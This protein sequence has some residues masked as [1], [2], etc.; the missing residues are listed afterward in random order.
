MPSFSVPAVSPDND[1]REII[2]ERSDVASEGRQSLLSSLAGFAATG[3]AAVFVLSLIELI[4]LQVHLSPEFFSLQE[5]LAFTAYSSVSLLSGA[6]I[7]LLV[8]V[9]AHAAELINRVALA[10][11]ARRK[12]PSRFDR[13]IA[14]LASAA[15]IAVVFYFQPQVNAYISG[16]II[17]AQKLPYIYGRLLRFDSILT[18][19]IL[20]ALFFCGRVVLL[21]VRASN[22]MPG[23]MRSAWLL[24]LSILIV[25]AY[26]IDSQYE[27]QLYE[28]TLHRS[29]FLLATGAAMALVASVYH[30]SS[31]ARSSLVLSRS[32]RL[33]AASLV[34]AVAL[35]LGVA[36]T[37]WHFGTNQNLKVH[38][39]SRTTQAKQHFKLAQWALDYDRDGYSPLL[40]GG[41]A[42]DGRAEINPERAEIFGDGIDN[43]LIGGDQP[44][45]ASTEWQSQWTALH[46]PSIPLGRRLNVIYV[47]IDT[48]RA[49]HI[50]A[51][52]Y[53]RETTPNLDKLAARSTLFENAFS[54]SANTYESAARFMKSSYW[55]ARVETWTEVLARNGYNVMLFPQ[56][57]L[58][59]LRR[60]VK[61]AEVAPGSDGKNLKQSIDLAIDTLSKTPRE[62]PFCAYI[63]AVDPHRPY[64][65]HKD[66]DFGSSTID[67]YDGEIAFTDHH[68]GRLFDW[69][70]RNGRLDD[71]MIT[72]WP[73]TPS[74]W[75]SAE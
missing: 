39:L 60:Y 59:M 71:T 74:R 47:F 5:R 12:T 70:E 8:G 43:N 61:G 69:M 25:A 64:A 67:L 27:V 37:F 50:G 29:M 58:S 52:G 31:R 73:I 10:G 22:S 33:S 56:R 41:D 75:A 28:Y 18:Y 62:T 35:S 38:L 45:N 44:D 21:S 26:Y 32:R 13:L 55:D 11:L 1:Q 24:G 16:L 30:S 36:F 54:P 23:I 66:F 14:G 7:G 46:S 17:E 48:V 63:Y 57:R 40:G 15:L 68:F 4:D 72:L 49:D 6:I 65:R 53:E 20:I 42:D 9:V 34:A 2:I 19:L 3:L 51:Y